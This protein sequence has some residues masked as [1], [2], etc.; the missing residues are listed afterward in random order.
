VELVAQLGRDP[1]AQHSMRLLGTSARRDQP[2][3][4]CNAMNM[5]VDGK[6]GTTHREHQHARRGLRPNAGKRLE[7]GVDLL[8]GQAGESCEV[9]GTLAL[10]Y[11]GEDLLDAPR[12]DVR[13][14]A[15]PNGV[16]DFF[17]GRVQDLVPRTEA[18]AQGG[19]GAPRVDVGGVLGQDRRDE[20][21]DG[22][23]RLAGTPVALVPAQAAV[24]RT[25]ASGRRCALRQKPCPRA[26]DANFVYWLMNARRTLPVGPLRCFATWSSASPFSSVSGL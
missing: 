5:R 18:R 22:R 3:S 10:L 11:G 23:E 19:E 17:R 25:D 12:L 16:R 6:R 1:P 13:E 4:S 8:V 24:E 7:I 9:D 20:F 14:A 2:E 21:V 26:N 15:G